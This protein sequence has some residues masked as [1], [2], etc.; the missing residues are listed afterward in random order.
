VINH[1]GSGI[2]EVTPNAR[3]LPCL[4]ATLWVAVTVAACTADT[5]FSSQNARAHVNQLAG[6]I[7]TRPAGSDANRRAREY[8]VDQLRF[9]GYTV[10]V[11]EAEASRPELGLSAHVFNI[12]AVVP[13]ASPDALGVM[14]HYDSRPTSPGAGD[15]ALGTAVALECARLLASRLDRQHSIMVLL[16]DAEEEGLMGAAALVRDPEVAAR[17]RAYVNL[18]AVGADGP[19]PLFQTGPGNAWMVHAWAHAAQAPRGGSYQAEVYRRLPS[20]TDFSIFQRAGIPGLNF[21]A[22]GDGYAYHTPRDTPDRLTTRAITDMGTTALAT[23]EA[24]DRTDLSQRS[25]Q[26]AVY[27]DLAGAGAIALRPSFSRAMSVLAIVLATIGLVRTTGVTARLGGVSGVVRTFA[28]AVIGLAAVAGALV[29]ATALL[30]ESREVYHPWYAHPARFWALLVLTLVVVV[31]IL[32]RIGDRLPRAWRAVRHPSAVW[33]VTLLFWL[34]LTVAAE[35]LV[36]AAAYLWAVPL[37]VLAAVAVIAPAAD[38]SAAHLAAVVVIA[39]SGA[40]WLPEAREML[41]FGVPLFGRLPIITPVTVFPSALLVVAVMTAPGMLALDMA[42]L[43][44]LPDARLTLGRRRIRALL[45]PALLVA[46]SVAFASCYLAEAYT[47]E[48]PLQRAVQYVADHSTGQAAWEVAGIEPGLDVDLSRG[49]PAGWVPSSGPLLPGVRASALPHPFAFRAPGVVDQSP[50]EAVLHGETTPDGAVR[51]E[52]TVRAAAAGLM[53][54]FAVPRDIAP[55]R[56]SL[57]GIVREGIWVAGYAAAPAGETVF[58]ATLPAAAAGRLGE[59]RVGAIDRGLPGG[60]G[61]LR[62]PAWLASARTVWHAR[63]LH[64]VAPEQGAPAPP[65]R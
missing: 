1:A 44:P 28:W 43:P 32:L 51:A 40:I 49:A 29:G 14:A 55:T 60:Q 27:F 53:L 23:V 64:L 36:P 33:M 41:R 2:A 13:G 34:A 65:L 8:L 47:L 48:R 22:V 39:A 50:I 57:P 37:L 31:E 18:D 17:V 6:T 38:R 56:S 20:D 58:S 61:W 16:T 7:G 5:R 54:L 25:A 42:T 59:L 15:D 9:F 63:S 21:A 24:L 19:V 11:Q 4:V 35:A 26:Q 12:I 62:Q 46:L 52:I 10:R 3:R 30:R 45:T